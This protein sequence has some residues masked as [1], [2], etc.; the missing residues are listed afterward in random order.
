MLLECTSVCKSFRN[1]IHCCVNALLDVT[2]EA[3]HLHFLKGSVLAER[4]AWREAQA[5]FFEAHQR[6]RQNADYAFNLAVSLDHLG[7]AGPAARYYEQAL[8][9]AASA[10][11]S[12]PVEQVQQRLRQLRQAEAAR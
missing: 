6:D 8:T 11:A 10:K 5:A 1:W 4:S 9:L 7:Q 2:P 12:F 3:A